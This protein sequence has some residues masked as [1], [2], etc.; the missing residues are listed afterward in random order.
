MELHIDI[1][2]TMG[3]V[4][5]SCQIC[6]VFV[7]NSMFYQLLHVQHSCSSTQ[8]WG[9]VLPSI[10]E[11]RNQNSQGCP[12]LLFLKRTLVSLCE[13]GTGILYTCS[14]WEVVDH[15]RSKIGPGIGLG[16][17]GLADECSSTELTLL[18]IW[19]IIS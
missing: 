16:T 5:P 13:K 10:V 9:N 2:K 18:L 3:E 6:Q 15:S 17:F 14:I 19:T 11:M 12:P 8:S 1:V 4:L 7:S